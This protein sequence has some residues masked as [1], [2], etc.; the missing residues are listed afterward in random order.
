[1]SFHDSFGYEP[2]R[3]AR[4]LEKRERGPLKIP[5]E[6]IKVLKPLKSY[7]ASDRI[8]FKNDLLSM[9]RSTCTMSL[10]QNEQRDCSSAQERTPSRRPIL[11]SFTPA[12]IRRVGTRQLGQSDF[13]TPSGQRQVDT[14]AR[15]ARAHA[16]SSSS[17]YEHPYYSGSDYDRPHRSGP[18]YER[19]HGRGSVYEH[20]HTCL[21]Y[22][23]DAA[24]E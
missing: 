16:H 20:P 1:M 18:A 2:K 13:V 11:S 15:T 5:S 7:S 8:E 24:D 4:G 17:A 3:R 19:P 10:L 12:P 21:L 14:R 23:S 22:T 6:L 9:L